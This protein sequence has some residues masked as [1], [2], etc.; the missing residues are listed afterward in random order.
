[1]LSEHFGSGRQQTCLDLPRSLLGSSCAFDF[2]WLCHL[3]CAIYSRSLYATSQQH[4]LWQWCTQWQS[5]RGA[6]GAPSNSSLMLFEKVSFRA[7]TPA[8]VIVRATFSWPICL[9]FFLF[10]SSENCLKKVAT[11]FFY[12]FPA[13]SGDETK[14]GYVE[15]HL[16]LYVSKYFG[17]LTFELWN[18]VATFCR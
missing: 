12:S 5:H 3:C 7:T 4:D 14:S 11:D 1:M 6:G 9:V 10:S 2:V 17:R 8:P 16:F 15:K 13:N 18:S